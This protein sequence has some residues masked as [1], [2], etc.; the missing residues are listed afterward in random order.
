MGISPEIERVYQQLLWIDRRRDRIL[1]SV[2][3]HFGSSLVEKITEPLEKSPLSGNPDYGSLVDERGPRDYL[4]AL[5]EEVEGLEASTITL[6]R[7][8][9]SVY[10]EHVD[11]QILFGARTAGQE[12]GRSFLATAKPALSGRA[13]LGVPEAV[14]AVFELA[15]NGLPW[16][17]NHFLCLRALGGSTVHFARSPHLK[18]WKKSGADPKFLY[19]VKASWINGMLDILSPLTV[20]SSH[21]AIEQG[22]EFGL[23][24]FYLRDQHA[25]P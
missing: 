22:A 20:F 12:A 11:E 1:S 15:Y 14:Q 7:K 19:L 10:P 4:A 23:A 16:E 5:A 24:H 3:A 18:V 17:K 13:Q 25:G 21:Q 2:S 6:L 8:H 9:V